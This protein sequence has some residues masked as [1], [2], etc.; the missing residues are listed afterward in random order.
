MDVFQY[1]I[2][3]LKK[4]EHRLDIYKM[5]FQELCVVTVCQRLLILIAILQDC[6]IFHDATIIYFEHH[7]SY[8]VL[9]MSLKK[10][11]HFFVCI[12]IQNFSPI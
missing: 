12:I 3:R 5:L 1:L 9:T 6:N 4:S 8:S 2:C 11:G 10:I 7:M